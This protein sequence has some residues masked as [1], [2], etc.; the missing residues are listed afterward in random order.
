M[1]SSPAGNR[2]GFS[3]GGGGEGE[4]AGESSACCRTL[5][6]GAGG[7]SMNPRAIVV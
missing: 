5:V 6:A 7:N 4:A 2:R 1:R 3:R